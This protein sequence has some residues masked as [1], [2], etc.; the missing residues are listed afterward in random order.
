M[1]ARQAVL[2][3]F[4]AL[5]AGCDPLT[6]AERRSVQRWLLCE[7]CVE[8]ERDSVVRIG[9]RAVKKLGK[10]LKGPPDEGVENIRLQVEANYRR[11]RSPAS[12]QQEY[13]SHYLDNYR[14]LYQSRSAVALGLIA[15]PRARELLLEAI[16]RDSTYRDDVRRVLGAAFGILLD[17]Q[18]P[19]WQRALPDAT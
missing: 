5:L 13:V 15:T 12:S 17:I 18:A 19:D 1:R 6:P 7:E 2:P 11:I 10:A 8:G 14:A 9:D 16:R 3:L 4:M